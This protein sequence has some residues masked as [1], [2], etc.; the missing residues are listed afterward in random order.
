MLSIWTVTASALV[1][2]SRLHV[3]TM[4][5]AP[6]GPVM[7]VPSAADALTSTLSA[8]HHTIPM[9]A[10]LA[11]SDADKALDHTIPMFAALAKSDADKA[12]DNILTSFPLYFTAFAL[13]A[14]VVQLIASFVLKQMRSKD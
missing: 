14:A 11:K 1:L 8:E 12:L 13:V 4:A 10:A 6:R 3:P 2:H 7:V 5:V 9:F